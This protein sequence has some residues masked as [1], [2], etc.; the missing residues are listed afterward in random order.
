MSGVAKP[1][2]LSPVDAAYELGAAGDVAPL[3]GAAELQ[4]HPVLAEQAEVVHRLEQDVGELGVADAGLEAALHGVAGQHPVDREVLADVAQEVDGRQRGGPVVVVDRGRG[5][6]A[7]EG[8]EARDLLAHPLG[9]LL[10]GVEGVE[11][12]LAGVA[13][14]ADHAGG[15][16]DQDVGRV[17]GQ[18]QAPRGDELD[19]VAHVEARR[20]RVE[21]DIEL[22]APLAQ[23]RAE[24]VAVGGVGHEAAP[25]QLVE[26]VGGR[27]GSS[28]GWG[29]VRGRAL[30]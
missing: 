21:A 5:V 28:F 23:R 29:R 13:R 10:D 9:P 17:A 2:A 24:R 22:D 1:W 26:C 15:A 18:L 25:L 12:A 4:R 7:L 11:R 30:A 27:H 3:V 16:A 19:E 14:V 8:D 20:G 6:V